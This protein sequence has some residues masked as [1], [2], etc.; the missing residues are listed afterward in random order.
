MIFLNQQE[1]GIYVFI[2][3]LVVGPI[4]ESNAYTITYE[5]ES[6]PAFGG[7]DQLVEFNHSFNSD[8][9]KLF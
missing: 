3:M 2:L 8:I 9:L 4:N 1:G 7:S 5:T 6:V